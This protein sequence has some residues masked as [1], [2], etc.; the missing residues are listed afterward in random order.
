MR[1]Y[2]I[3]LQVLCTDKFPLKYSNRLQQHYLLLSLQKYCFFPNISQIWSMCLL[4]FGMLQLLPTYPVWQPLC[5]KASIPL[6]LCHHPLNQHHKADI[7]RVLDKRSGITQQLTYFILQY[8]HIWIHLVFGKYHLVYAFFILH[9]SSC[10]LWPYSFSEF[11]L[12]LDHLLALKLFAD[13][14]PGKDI[15][16]FEQY[17][18]WFAFCLCI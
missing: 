2:L 18:P 8:I 10:L 5:P 7:K 12:C 3:R 4:V 16:R 11:F 15:Q 17:R 13:G 6:F 14:A 9:F 1:R